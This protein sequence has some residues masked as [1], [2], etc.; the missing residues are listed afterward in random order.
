MKR[1]KQKGTTNSL[2]K[3]PVSLKQYHAHKLVVQDHT[4]QQI[5]QRSNKESTLEQS[6]VDLMAEVNTNKLH[7]ILMQSYS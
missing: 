1:P 3:R 4:K 2:L 5:S 6:L 7:S